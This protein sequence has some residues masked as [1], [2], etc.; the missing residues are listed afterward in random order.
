M[1]RIACLGL[2][3]LTLV[4]CG[5]GPNRLPFDDQYF[6][7]TAKPVERG[8]REVFEVVVRQASKS[9]TGARQAAAHEATGYCIRWFGRSD[10]DWITDPA[11]EAVRIENDLLTV[12]GTCT[13]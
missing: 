5:R 10:I 9:E 13:G 11:D 1:M 6:R 8:E 3:I 12:R 7:A 4:A 2:L